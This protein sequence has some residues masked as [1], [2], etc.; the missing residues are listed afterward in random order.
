[1][2]NWWRQGMMGGTKAHYDYIKAFPETD[3]ADDL[4]AIAVPTLVMHGT[5]DQ[6]VPISASAR[7]SAPLLRNAQTKI[8]EGLGHGMCTIN[9]DVVNPDLLAFPRLAMPPA[10]EGLLNP[11]ASVAR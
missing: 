5:D 8:Y 3:F 11:T 1:M 4:R 9:P 7:L 2:T 6:I 10:G